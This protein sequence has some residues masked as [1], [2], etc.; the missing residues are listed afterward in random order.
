MGG[1]V[2]SFS[3][4]ALTGTIMTDELGVLPQR[5][6]DAEAADHNEDGIPDPYLRDYVSRHPTI[7]ESQDE[8]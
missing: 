2:P 4:R 8:A 1:D 7:S 5:F 3:V 6:R